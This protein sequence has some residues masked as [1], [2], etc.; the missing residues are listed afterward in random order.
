[1]LEFNIDASGL[2]HCGKIYCKNIPKGG[3]L[4]DFASQSR[5]P[6]KAVT[7]LQEFCL[8]SE[9]QKNFR[10]FFRLVQSNS[11]GIIFSLHIA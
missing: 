11:T 4:Y 9:T 7:D 2:M 5:E 10:I 1:M 3:F 6:L 8:F